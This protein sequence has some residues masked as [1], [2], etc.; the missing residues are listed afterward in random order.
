MSLSTHVLDTHLGRPAKDVPVVLQVYQGNGEWQDLSFATTNDDGRVPALLPEGFKMDV[1]EGNTITLRLTFD[2][3][4]YFQ[5][6]NV[7]SFFYPYVSIMF[8]V[9]TLTE[10]YHVPLLLSPFGYSTYRGS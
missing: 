6:Q 7:E 8:D 5:A 9:T 4:A 1:P 2:T 3:G 10:H